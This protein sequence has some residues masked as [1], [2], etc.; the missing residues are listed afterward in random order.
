MGGQLSP[1]AL[2]Q[3]RSFGNELQQ[4]WVLLDHEP[5]DRGT[6]PAPCCWPSSPED[7]GDSSTGPLQPAPCPA[8]VPW[9]TG[10]LRALLSPWALSCA[11]NE[12]PLGW[13]VSELW[14]RERSRGFAGFW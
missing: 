3:G 1:L 13:G 14:S 5:W 7:L 6:L 2:L 12:G 9:L 4:S 8:W 11:S 10:K